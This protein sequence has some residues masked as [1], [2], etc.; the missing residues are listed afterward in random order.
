MFETNS[1]P[2]PRIDKSM[3]G[4]KD[5]ADL[6]GK[7]SKPT[8]FPIRNTMI[9]AEKENLTSCSGATAASSGAAIGYA[10]AVVALRSIFMWNL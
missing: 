10:V 1:P 4:I 7:C 3:R 5:V 2:I 6:L 8:S 9:G